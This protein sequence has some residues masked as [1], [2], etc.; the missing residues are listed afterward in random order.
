MVNIAIYYQKSEQETSEDS[1]NRINEL[2]Q[3]LEEPHTIKGVFIDRQVESNALIELLSSPLSQIEFIYINKP[4]KNEFDSEL[5][6][7]L[8]RTENFKIKYFDEI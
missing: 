4:F 7:Q 6:H 5:V 8:A 3:V 2:I 1:V